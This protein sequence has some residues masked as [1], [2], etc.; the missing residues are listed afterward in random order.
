MLS[1][2][3]IAKYET[4]YELWYEVKQWATD[5]A[6]GGNKYTFAN[7]GREGHDGTAGALPSSTCTAKTEPVT[8]INWRD[9]IVW[10]NAYSE[11]DGKAPSTSG[12]FAHKW[13]GTNTDRYG[14]PD[15]RYKRRSRP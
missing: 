15:G 14:P 6:R 7:A 8:G 2:F 10:C 5:A 9:A 11:M 3:R 12:T 13:A 4:S 1:S